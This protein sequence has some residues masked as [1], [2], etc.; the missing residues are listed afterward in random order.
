MEVSQAGVLSSPSL[1]SPAV[2]IFGD[3]L[4]QSMNLTIGSRY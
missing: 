3:S 2:G 1:Y 4:T